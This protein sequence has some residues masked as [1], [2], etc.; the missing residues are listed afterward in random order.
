MNLVSAVGSNF[1]E[2]MFDKVQAKN[3]N[4]SYAHME[5]VQAKGMDASNSIMRDMFF[6]YGDAPTAL[7]YF[8]SALR[9]SV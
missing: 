8:T 2:A 5:L 6:M 3:S 4:F 1:A 9:T 7:A